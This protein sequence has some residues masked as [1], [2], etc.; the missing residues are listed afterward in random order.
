MK[1]GLAILIVILVLLIAVWYIALRMETPVVRTVQS[2]V[3]PV[4]TALYACDGGKTIQAAYFVGTS[5]P[6][7]G[8]GEPPTPGGSVQIRLSDGRSMT[9]PQTIS[10]DGARYANTDESFVF[11][12][13]GNGAIVLE[14]DQETDYTNCVANG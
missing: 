5:T 3:Q 8:P 14:N 2:A 1:K 13:K 7:A 12:N 9:L 4:A 11:W 10:A 6:P